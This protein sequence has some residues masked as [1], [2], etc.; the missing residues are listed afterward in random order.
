MQTWEIVL[1]YLKVFLSSQ[2]VVGIVVLVFVCLFRKQISGLIERIATI[3]IPGG[4]LTT[5][6]SS[7]LTDEGVRSKEPP[8]ELPPQDARVALPQSIQLT[9][10]Q[11]SQIKELLQAER[12]KAYLWEYRYLNYCELPAGVRDLTVA[13]V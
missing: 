6:Q 10:E 12:A 3:R 4:E 2:V 1:E 7:K 8:P 13:G 11:Q 5:S 9:P